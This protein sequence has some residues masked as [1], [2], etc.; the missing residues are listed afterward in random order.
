M[1]TS[2]SS[3]WFLSPLVP[4]DRPGGVGGW[5]GG[6][7]GGTCSS[8]PDGC[9]LFILTWLVFSHQSLISSLRSCGSMLA[10]N[11]WVPELILTPL[12]QG[13]QD[14]TIKL[15]LVR[16][17]PSGGS[18]PSILLQTLCWDPFSALQVWSNL[19]KESL[20]KKKRWN[21]WKINPVNNSC[22][23]WVHLLLCMNAPAAPSFFS[24]QLEVTRLYWSILHDVPTRKKNR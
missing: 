7:K 19:I 13:Y 12:T 5:V 20:K 11:K 23:F 24:C 14:V 16:F 1:S 4:V 2:V 15:T 3:D 22:L 6:G 9:N 17:S 10:V 21:A 8:Q 18:L